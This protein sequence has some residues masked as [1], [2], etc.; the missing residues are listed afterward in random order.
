MKSRTSFSKLTVFKKNI[1]RFA[2]IWALYFI[3]LMLVLVDVSY[4]IAS[5]SRVCAPKGAEGLHLT[6]HLRAKSRLRRLRS[7]TRLRAQSH[8]R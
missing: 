5:P 6:P 2:P 1:T 8:L 7:E 3:G 4:H